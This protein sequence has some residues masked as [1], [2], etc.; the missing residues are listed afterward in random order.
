M[1]RYSEAWLNVYLK[2][3]Q[4]QVVKKIMFIPGN[5]GEIGMQ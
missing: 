5:I 4:L 1:R 2:E 3:I